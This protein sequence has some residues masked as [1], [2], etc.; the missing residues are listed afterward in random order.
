MPT[1]ADYRALATRIAG[2]E[3]P[4]DPAM[5][6]AFVRQIAQESSQFSPDIVEGH[7]SSPAGARGIAQLTSVHWN[8]VNPLDPEAALHY[9][10]RYLKE[11]IAA[12]G[13][14]VAKGFAAYNA[15]PARVRRA[16][17]WG[18]PNWVAA[19]PTETRAYLGIIRPP[20]LAGSR[21]APAATPRHPVAGPISQG[22]G[23]T[24]EP[25]DAP[26]GGYAHF[27][28]GNDY[29]VPVGT[30]VQAVVGGKVIAAGPSEEGWGI[31]VWVQ[32]PDGTIHNYG[33]LSEAGVQVGQT[34]QP[35][36][37]IAKS[38]NTGKS[39]GPHLSYD[40]W[41]PGAQGNEYLDPMQFV[42]GGGGMVTSTSLA[43][44]TATSPTNPNWRAESIASLNTRRQQLEQ[45]I[46]QR[47]AQL[48][49]LTGDALYAAQ[50]QLAQDQDSLDTIY[51]ILTNLDKTK[52]QTPVE[53]TIAGIIAN[54]V[55][56]QAELLGAAFG[57]RSAVSNLL[58]GLSKANLDAQGEWVTREIS[59]GNL[60]LDVAA[61]IVRA[62]AAQQEAEHTRNLFALN[63][64]GFV[65]KA[66]W[67]YLNRLLPPGTFDEPGFEP[68]GA[69]AAAFTDIGLP[70][71]RMPAIQA[72]RSMVDPWA[73]YGRAQETVPAVRDFGASRLEK[74]APEVAAIQNP[75][76][77]PLTREGLEIPEPNDYA[78]LMAG[79]DFATGLALSPY[80]GQGQ[81]QGQTPP[82]D[83]GQQAGLQQWLEQRGVG[84][85]PPVVPPE[86]QV[87]PPGTQM[88]F[89]P[90]QPSGYRTVFPDQRGEGM[91]ND[92]VRPT[93]PATTSTAPTRAGGGGTNWLPVAALASNPVTAPVTFA[94][95]TQGKRWVKKAGKLV[96]F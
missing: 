87:N 81:D 59:L 62:H 36:Q 39:T 38:G 61:N 53:Q 70:P 7:R 26:Y 32:A 93:H 88:I 23:P 21:G 78:S 50:E 63:L 58:L 25:L 9:G 17:A 79:L 96:P 24:N 54:S 2:E 68:G 69:L 80:M 6:A 64:A 57:E 83:T 42:G 76:P 43:N 16:V 5:Q 20:T 71:I 4:N 18:G 73:I 45:R 41:R 56:A 51:G 91:S 10:A 67:E 60:R 35:G 37:V 15:G 31:R 86:R 92:A 34:V 65:Q 14:D 13:G 47:E 27:N 84:Y 90:T 1:A 55:S 44:R 95:T 82:A 77:V 30:P 89:D 74:L 94:V 11:N 85:Q 8:R 22:F 29:A 49:T 46:A 40:V 75:K 19:L 3:F 12:F 28:K 52:E 72:P 48:A 66:N 33:H